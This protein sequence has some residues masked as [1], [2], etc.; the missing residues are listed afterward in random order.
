MRGPTY[1]LVECKL[2]SV[3]HLFEKHHAYGGVGSCATYVFAVVESGQPIAGYAWNPP[4]PSAARSVCPEAPH[5]VLSLSR[6]VALPKSERKLKHISKPLRRQMKFMIDRTRWPVLVT[7][8]DEGLGHSGFVYQCSGWAKTSRRKVPQYERD[9]VRTSTYSGGRHS[10]MGL[11]KIGH[12][13]IQRWENWVCEPETVSD[14]MRA[15]GWKRVPIPGK[16]WKSGNQAHK[17]VKQ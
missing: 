9:G 16:F 11:K 4:P 13:Y 12:A 5:A 10:L 3:K 8:S 1:D 6:M 17:W 14:H 7:Y 15:A 2:S